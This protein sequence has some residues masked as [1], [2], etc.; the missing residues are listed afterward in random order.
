MDNPKL[1]VQNG[2]DEIA[3]TYFDW[4]SGKP[5][6]RLDYVDK[7]LSRLQSPWEADVLELGCGAGVPCTRLLAQRCRRVF[8]N[9]I[10]Q[11]Q[12]DLA[13]ANVPEENVDFIQGDMTSLKFECSVLQAVVAFYSIIHLPRD[14]QCN[15][16]QQVWKWLSPT[17]YLLCNLGVADN[18]G[19]TEKWL[20]SQMYWS[21][22]DAETS[23]EMLKDT[24]F[25]IIQS[26]VLHDDEDGRLVPFL[27]VLASKN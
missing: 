8:A 12:I 23:L 3:Q 18:P 7:L 6:A 15:L 22:F 24:G 21:S 19:K 5:T 20:G 27:W 11:S 17:G 25:S 2:Y 16:I 14:E 4:T 10:S 1:V 13:K 26:E 9:D